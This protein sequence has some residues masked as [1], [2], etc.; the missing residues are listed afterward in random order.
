MDEWGFEP[1]VTIWLRHR[2][3]VLEKSF[4]RR[5]AKILHEAKKRRFAFPIPA[6]FDRRLAIVVSGNCENR[7]V[8]I[9]I[10]LIELRDVL[11]AFPV[12]IHDVSEMEEK[13]RP[14]SPVRLCD[15]ILHRGGD[16]VLRLIA[17]DAAC[18]AHRMKHQTAAL[19]RF[20]RH[21]GKNVL[22]R[23]IEVRSGEGRQ[24]LKTRL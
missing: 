23:K 19:F 14:L 15:L 4:R 18:I 8:V 7:R 11:A 5:T 2:R 9:L 6:R 12:E 10:G 17:M 20:L 22:Q 3:S 21:A 24:R 16:R 13:S 1:P